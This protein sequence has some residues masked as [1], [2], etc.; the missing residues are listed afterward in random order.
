ME[1]AGGACLFLS[2]NIHIRDARQWYKIPPPA[3]PASRHSPCQPGHR[4]MTSPPNHGVPLIHLQQWPGERCH[5][6]HR[7]VHILSS[8]TMLLGIHQITSWDLL[9]DGLRTSLLRYAL[10]WATHPV[11]AATVVCILFPFSETNWRFDNPF[12]IFFPT[13]RLKFCCQRHWQLDSI[14]IKPVVRFP[15]SS[16][17]KLWYG[18]ITIYA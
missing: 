7:P 6:R 12:R 10:R 9:K 2:T 16:M 18:C 17:P 14:T 8:I 15:F 5:H 3:L 11:L 1:E 4:R 13:T